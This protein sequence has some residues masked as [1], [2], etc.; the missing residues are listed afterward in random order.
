MRYFICGSGIVCRDWTIFCVLDGCDV[1]LIC[2]GEGI[3]VDLR[4]GANEQKSMY[5]RNY[6]YMDANILYKVSPIPALNKSIT[7]SF[8]KPL[9]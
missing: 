8:M 7:I 3:I 2:S 5:L 4:Y 9:V 1:Y 6:T